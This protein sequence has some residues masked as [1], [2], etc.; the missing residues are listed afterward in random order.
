[1]KQNKRQTGT[2]YED[3][4]VLF[5]KKKG[6][7][8]LSRNYYCKYGEIDIIAR[9]GNYLVFIEVKYRK[10]GNAGSPEAAV[11]YQKR[12]HL[13]QASKMYLVNEIGNMEIPCRFDVVAIL[14]KQIHL[15]QN[16]FEFYEG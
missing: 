12:K 1:M 13:W 7:Q 9:D 2:A 3:T 4:A 6:Y 10:N 16:A 14:G 15:I 8:I 5:L 11:S